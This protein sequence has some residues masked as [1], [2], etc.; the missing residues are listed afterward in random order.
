MEESQGLVILENSMNSRFECMAKTHGLAV[1]YANLDNF[2]SGNKAL[3]FV[4]R[5]E[6]KDKIF[7]VVNRLT[8]FIV[9]NN[10]KR[11]FFSTAEG[12]VSHNII[13]YIKQKFPDVE[14]VALQHGLFTL[15][16][17]KVKE[18]LRTLINGIFKSIYGIFPIGAGFGGIKMDK[19]FVYS[20]REQ[21]FLV[22]H[23]DWKMEHV[24]V[25]LEFIKSD[26]FQELKK[27]DLRQDDSCAIF[28]T[29]CLSLVGLCSLEQEILYNNSIIKSLAGK[30]DRL[31][32]KGH[33][34]CSNNITKMQ[35]PKN[36]VIVDDMFD[37]FVQCKT[38]YSYFSTALLDAKIFNL[39][40]V[41]IMV[42]GLKVDR[43]IYE[44]FDT[45]LS[46][47]DVISI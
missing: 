4:K 33:P 22:E 29:Q 16:H 7:D 8:S 13:Y 21:M 24:P 25:K 17:S 20:K 6:S 38:A 39:K 5:L 23:W 11:L 34:A 12:Y 42:K 35:L 37:G 3:N 1:F 2:L 28:L 31:F 41:G 47:E 9:Q 10:L 32:L 30:Y 36:V 14:Y 46:F 44:T 40:T 18:G 26:V 45:T 27:R 15:E 19:Y 43:K